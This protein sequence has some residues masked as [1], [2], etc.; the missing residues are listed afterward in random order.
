MY[1]E[2]KLSAQIHVGDRFY[3]VYLD[4][5]PSGFIAYRQVEPQVYFI[6]KFYLKTSSQN[7]GIGSKAFQLLLDLIPDAKEI[8][9]QVNR[10]NFKSINF[11]F[12]NGFKIAYC[13]DNQIGEGYEMNDFMMIWKA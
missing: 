12:K 10:K 8:R 13:M 4:E 5:Q 1:S 7:S 2:E 6:D 9:L 11:Y 3:L